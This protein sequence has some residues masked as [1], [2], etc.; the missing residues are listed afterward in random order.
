[1]AKKVFT[2]MV[3]V[4]LITPSLLAGN[5]AIIRVSCTIPAI[6]GVNV[7]PQK[8]DNTRKE[9]KKEKQG[10]TFLVQTEKEMHEGKLV[11]ITTI[12]DR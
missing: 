1:M 9:E 5:S 4:Q 8:E 2:L 3:I 12:V 10:K 6:V 7:P 11:K